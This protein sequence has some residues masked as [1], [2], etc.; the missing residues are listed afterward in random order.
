MQPMSIP[1][2]AGKVA[3]KQGLILGLILT[4]VAITIQ[5]TNTFVNNTYEARA[6]ASSLSIASILFGLV[7][8]FIAGILAAKQTGKVSTGTFAGM[9]TGSIFGIINLVVSMVVFFQITLPRLLDSTLAASS[10]NPEVFKTA[11]TIGGVGALI[12]GSLFAVGLGAGLGALGGLIG[13]KTSKIQPVV[14]VPV[15]PDYPYQP[16][17]GQPMPYAQPMTPAQ[18]APMPYVPPTPYEQPLAPTLP[19][20]ADQPYMEQPQ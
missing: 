15:Y 9:W 13:K 16:Y 8:Y 2:K 3:F 14:A 18:P 17:P 1:P 4:G 5:L 12:F 11:A 19:V 10:P 7:A 20:N 6:I